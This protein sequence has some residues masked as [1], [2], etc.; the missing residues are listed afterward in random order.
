MPGVLTRSSALLT[1]SLT[2]PTRLRCPQVLLWLCASWTVALRLP[3]AVARGWGQPYTAMVIVPTG[4]GAAIG[5]YAGDAMPVA[6]AFTAVADRVITHPNVMNGAQLYWPAPELYYVEGYALDEFAAGRWG[7]RPVTSQRVGL[8]LDAAIEPELRLRHMQAADACRATLG[9][10]VSAYAVTDAPLGVE[11]AMSPAG[12]SWGTLGNPEALLRAARRLQEEG[13][14]AIAVV[15]RFPDDE[16]EEM[17]ASYRA[18]D[19][20]DAVGGAEAII[21]HLVTKELGLPCAHAPAL[22]ALD[23]EPELSPRACAEELGHT[24]LPCVLVNLARAPSLLPP[25]SHGRPTDVWRD[26]VDA[27]VLPAGAC[28]GAAV[29]SLQAGRALVV[30]V[31]DN[32]CALDVQG[33]KLGME[34]VVVVRSYMEALGLL[35]AHKAGVNPACLTPEIAPIRELQVHLEPES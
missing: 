34:G 2:N 24:F 17:L 15:A 31:E 26:D 4:I 18:G 35:A 20:V 22:P 29:M 19:G 16:D 28:G 10:T 13:C 14:T 9:V 12:A 3:D 1:A 7:L 11:I 30:A 32:E 27:V 23:I 33:S 21:S 6:R 8:L 5:G 25:G